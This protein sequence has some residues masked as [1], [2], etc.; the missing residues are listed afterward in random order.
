MK[1][2]LAKPLT[3]GARRTLGDFTDTLLQLAAEKSFDQI[4]VNELCQRADYPR[5]T[6][7]NYFDDKYDLLDYCWL[8][9]S[10]EFQFLPAPADGKENSDLLMYFDRLFAA[11]KQK[12]PTFSTI[13]KF[14]PVDGTLV[15]SFISFFRGK[16]RVVVSSCQILQ[17]PDLPPE[18]AA[19]HVANSIL[20]LIEWV[21]LKN[22]VVSQEQL[23]QYL[24]QLLGIVKI[25][26]ESI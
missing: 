14:N 12:L 20:L 13:M 21:F 17:T 22:H 18:L 15:N 11:L 5:A 25:P 7:Y 6:F 8:H 2:D 16:L 23:H 19:E 1:Y 24:F 4:S 9:I 3:R 26:D 10:Q